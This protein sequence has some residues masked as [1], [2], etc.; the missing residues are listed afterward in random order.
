MDINDKLRVFSV[1]VSTESKNWKTESFF[2][3]F[4]KCFLG[5]R[6]KGIGKC[7]SFI[8]STKKPQGIERQ[9]VLAQS[10]PH[11]NWVSISIKAIGILVRLEKNPRKYLNCILVFPSMNELISKA[12]NLQ[13]LHKWTVEQFQQNAEYWCQQ[14]ARFILISGRLSEE[15]ISICTN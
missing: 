1:S 3:Y 8:G 5:I 6:L 15:Q 2:L 12:L 11:G 4:Q 10:F 7:N 14:V 13:R 9:A